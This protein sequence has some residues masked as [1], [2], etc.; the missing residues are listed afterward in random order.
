MTLGIVGVF[1]PLLPTTIF[2][3]VSL[4]AFSKSSQRLHDYI[5]HHPRFGTA[6][7]NWKLYGIV[8]RSAKIGALVVMLSS[9]VLLLFVLSIPEW[10][11]VT[12][13]AIMAVV[14]LWLLSRPEKPAV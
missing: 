12:A 11:A 3:L 7:R 8:P 13:V 5:W 1:V 9:A 2:M 6:A 14:L 4:W 10:A